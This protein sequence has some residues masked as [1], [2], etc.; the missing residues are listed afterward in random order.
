MAA[1]HPIVR[2]KVTC[3]AQD[4]NL[5]LYTGAGSGASN[6]IYSS[7][8]YGQ[9]NPGPCRLVVSSAN[10]GYFAVLDSAN[11]VLFI[12]PAAAATSTAPPATTLAPAT[13]TLPPATTLAPATTTLA[14]KS[15]TPPPTSSSLSSGTLL[16]GQSLPQARPSHYPGCIRPLH[17]LAG[18]C[19]AS[20]VR[21]HHCKSSLMLL[22]VRDHCKS[23]LYG[24]AGHKP[25]L[26]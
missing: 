5:V 14:P 13:T 18:C 11:H 24:C 20:S 3:A 1:H 17:A 15:S 19:K 7:G 23:K 25:V 8:T 2:I 12:R 26:P 9:G 22:S 10:G 16:A 6:A 21:D 4:C